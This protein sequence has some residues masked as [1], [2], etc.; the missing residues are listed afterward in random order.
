MERAGSVNGACSTSGKI[1]FP[2]SEKGK[3]GED[4]VLVK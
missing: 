2:L 1:V 4:Q 3:P